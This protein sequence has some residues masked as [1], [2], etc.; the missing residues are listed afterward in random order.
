MPRSL[1]RRPRAARRPATLLPLLPLLAALAACEAR[2]VAPEPPPPWHIAIVSGDLQT[3]SVTLPLPEPLTVRVTDD[4]GQ[5]AAG[6]E[7]R[8][9]LLEGG[10]LVEPHI[11]ESDAQGLATA[12]LLLG[13]QPTQHLVLAEVEGGRSVTFRAYA[14]VIFASVAAGWRHSCALTTVGRAWC[15]GGNPHGQLGTPD[16]E[17]RLAPTLVESDARFASLSAG[18]SHTCALTEEGEAWCWGA[19][20]EGQL[21][22]GTTRSRGRP[23][24][25]S[26]GLRFE[27]L[28]T[29]YVNTCGLTADGDAWCWGAHNVGQ[30]GTG[31][32]TS[33]CGDG[34]NHC[35]LEPTPVAGEHT[36]VDITMGES[37]G[38]GIDDAGVAWCWGW[39][40]WGEVGAG[41]YGGV[42]DAPVE[43]TPA[44]D[45]G[46]VHFT[47]IEAG[48]LRTCALDDAGAA[49][50]WGNNADGALGLEA[51]P[52][53]L[54][55]PRHVAGALT[56]TDLALG[57]SYICGAQPDG[58]LACWARLI[59]QAGARAAQPTPQTL[60]PLPDDIS[61][62]VA[63]ACGMIGSEIWCWG[64]NAEGQLGTGE[65]GGEEAQPVRLSWG[66]SR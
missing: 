6:I 51:W 18:W 38:C 11:T 36:F 15:W 43:V 66:G 19:N 61:F 65:A 33:T 35:V 28:V 23:Q 63:H 57:Q 44:R 37:H 50:C 46:D 20:G 40:T 27:R 55:E 56:F 62:G 31:P 48:S 24:P 32:V 54:A 17:P 64:R 39:N 14:E 26:G 9:R 10:G 16:T 53:H 49:L 47:A 59:G 8:W 1:P 58:T 34:V 52:W 41:T 60:N 22:D 42:F 4:A 45:A 29:S 2:S 3:T 30:A 7:V 5:P 21:G 13:S 12:T 25:V